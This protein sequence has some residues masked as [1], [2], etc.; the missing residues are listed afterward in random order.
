MPNDYVQ[1]LNQLSPGL[2]IKLSD[3][4]FLIQLDEIEEQFKIKAVLI[5]LDLLLGLINYADLTG[6]LRTDYGFDDI[7]AEEVKEKFGV[8]IEE[9]SAGSPPESQPPAP[10]EIKSVSQ[11]AGRLNVSSSPASNKGPSLPVP[12]VST[13]M[14]FSREDNEEIKKYSSFVVPESG[15]DYIQSAQE[16]LSRFGYQTSDELMAKRLVNIV[17]SHLKGVRDDFETKEILMKNRKVAGL[18]LSDDQSDQ[19]LKLINEF[20]GKSGN[21]TAINFS[22]SNVALTESIVSLPDEIKSISR[23]NSVTANS[24]LKIEM[25]DG[26]PVVRLPEDKQ[27]INQPPIAEDK[28]EASALPQAAEKELP[29]TD[30]NA[31]IKT[32]ILP[33]PTPA[34]FIAEKRI[35]ETV[36]NS[37]TANRPNLDDVKFEKRLIGPIEELGNMTLIDFRRLA[38]DP[39]A[40][41]NKVKE[42]IDILEDQGLE[43]KIT[44][45]SAWHK[46]EINRFY[47]M[48]GQAGMTEG[49]TIEGVIKERLLSGKPTL[50]LD[51]FQAVMEL[52]RALRY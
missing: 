37:K 47:R 9:L 28:F 32:I 16:I 12:K 40:A 13:T 39:K 46:N 26:L 48:L 36:L 44:G 38:A 25:E 6:K 4:S 15:N 7:L 34:P 50:S 14:T 33:P 42:K 20:L 23:Q 45:I 5:L 10:A 35:P 17:A 31:K 52:N 3:E 19:L 1:K 29:L 30:G 18:E 27:E 41:V 8:L 24:D 2:R 21:K 49:K 22:P 51:E 11:G 43:K